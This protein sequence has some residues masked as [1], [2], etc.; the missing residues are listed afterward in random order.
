MNSK[1]KPILIPISTQ[2]ETPG[3]AVQHDAHANLHQQ[4]QRLKIESRT[5]KKTQKLVVFPEAEIA[6]EAERGL[7]N[8]HNVED[9]QLP[10]VELYATQSLRRVTAY[11]TAEYSCSVSHSTY[12]RAGP[13]ESETFRNSSENLRFQGSTKLNDMMRFFIRPTTFHRT[14]S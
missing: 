11:L 4:K 8:A 12:L 5:S 1:N 13:S 10:S 2:A 14:R 3:T 9:L 7:P 6:G